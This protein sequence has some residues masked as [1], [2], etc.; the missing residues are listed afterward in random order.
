MRITSTL[1]P[2]PQKKL[3]VQSYEKNKEKKKV[4]KMTYKLPFKIYGCLGKQDVFRETLKE[5]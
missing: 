2:Y 3:S 5:V 1:N 4:A